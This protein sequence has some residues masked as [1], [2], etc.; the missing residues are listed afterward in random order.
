MCCGMVVQTQH[1]IPF[2]RS[3]ALDQGHPFIVLLVLID[4]NGISSKRVCLGLYLIVVGGITWW[5]DLMPA[6]PLL[7]PSDLPSSP[8]L[9]GCQSG[10]GSPKIVPLDVTSST[11]RWVD[12]ACLRASFADDSVMQGFSACGPRPHDK[13]AVKTYFGMR[14]S[15]MQHMTQPVVNSLVILMMASD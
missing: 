7:F 15:S 8:R 5:L 11:F 2:A 13:L 9:A 14:L 4:P 1:Q 3:Y 10:G 12:A 6:G